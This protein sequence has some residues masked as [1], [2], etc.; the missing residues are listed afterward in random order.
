MATGSGG[1]PE[2]A[3]EKAGIA[4]ASGYGAWRGGAVPESAM[5]CSSDCV[6]SPGTCHSRASVQASA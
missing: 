1:V 5:A 4:A 6:S 2:L 3:E